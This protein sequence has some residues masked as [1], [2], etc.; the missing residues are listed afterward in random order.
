MPIFFDG[1]LVAWTAA[2]SHTTETGAVEPGGMP[3]AARARFEEGMNL[4]PMRVGTNFRINGDVLE[5]FAAFGIRAEANVTVDMRAR[6]TTADR[7]RV[8]LLEMFAREGKEFVIGL[9]RRMLDEAEAGARKR[10]A[11]WAD[12]TYRAVTFS[13]AAGLAGGLMRNCS[14]TMTK[15]ACR[16]AG[17]ATATRWTAIPLRWSGTSSGT[18]CRRRSRGASTG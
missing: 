5:M 16:P 7:V 12:G 1:E 14:M 11:H 2:L 8:R 13:D 6:A 10:I 17:P 18:S 15:Q 9:M 3:L 4:P